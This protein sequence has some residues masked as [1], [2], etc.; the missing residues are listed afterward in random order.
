MLINPVLVV[1]AFFMESLAILVGSYP[2]FSG[3]QAAIGRGRLA[4]S[5]VVAGTT[6]VMLFFVVF[7]R[8]GAIFDEAVHCMPHASQVCKTPSKSCHCE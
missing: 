5:G 4:G 7:S 3:G 2:A 8:V 1:C 6:F